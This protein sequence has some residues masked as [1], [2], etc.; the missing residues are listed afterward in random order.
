[1]TGRG[2]ILD[3]K[4]KGI[5]ND[6]WSNYFAWLAEHGCRFPHIQIATMMDGERA[7]VALKN[8]VAKDEVLTVPR[9]LMISPETVQKSAFGKL[10][11][12][13]EISLHSSQTLIALFILN[14]YQRGDS[15]WQPFLQRLPRVY[16]HVPAYFDARLMDEL[17]GSFTHRPILHRQQVIRR[18]FELVH[19]K[20][21]DLY[22]WT[23]E[24]VRWAMTVVNTRCF[25]LPNSE[26][27]D[28]PV[29]V[30]LADMINHG[31]PANAKWRCSE[32]GG[33]L[34]IRARGP[35]PAGRQVKISYGHKTKGRFFASYG[36]FD[37][38]NDRWQAFV[39]VAVQD[40]DPH[41]VAKNAF[42]TRLQGPQFALHFRR[43]EKLGRTLKAIRCVLTD[44]HAPRE[45]RMVQAGKIVSQ[46]NEREAMLLLNK[47]CRE[48]LAQFPHSLESDRLLLLDETR[49]AAFSPHEQSVIQLRCSE[50]QV[51]HRVATF[52]ES[53]ADLLEGSAEEVLEV[54]VKPDAVEAWSPA[55]R[56]WFQS[57]SEDMVPVLFSESGSRRMES[58]G[59]RPMLGED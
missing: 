1:M 31:E 42:L 49:L 21:G 7:L 28:E 50:K 19:E 15:F 27:K 53:I 25:S 6:T 46:S 51:L 9:A 16:D 37:L 14:E 58:V 13:R 56:R 52:A 59:S 41:A 32:P 35:L 45:R 11:A 48:A 33:D 26:G 8:F 17:K 23:F 3:S 22:P 34:E 29:V 24:E 12:E 57:W 43:Y 38:N 54:L 40:E 10:V 2:E 30:P 5:A 55:L 4:A 36:F 47:L 44:W 20:L 39:P 18:E